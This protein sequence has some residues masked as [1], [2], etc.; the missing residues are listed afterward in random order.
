M[1][2]LDHLA[3]AVRN[4]ARSLHFYRD[5]I[6]VDGVVH[7]EE[8]GFVITTTKGVAFTLF[9][10]QPPANPGEFHLGV[11]LA[12][13]DVVRARRAELR[14]L[15]VPEIDWWDQPGYVSIKVPDPDGYIVEL[16]WDEKY[17]ST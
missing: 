4:P 3:L 2:E 12:D 1:A 13:G 15:G 16:A 8:Y 6:A 11:S 10:G 14:S 17:S 5:T 7:E 9:K